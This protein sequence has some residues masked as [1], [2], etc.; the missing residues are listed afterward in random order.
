MKATPDFVFHVPHLTLKESLQIFFQSH[1]SFYKRASPMSESLDFFLVTHLIIRKSLRIF[2]SLTRP[3]PHPIFSK[4]HVL[5]SLFGIFPMVYMFKKK[6]SDTEKCHYRDVGPRKNLETLSSGEEESEVG[7]N[8]EVGWGVELLKDP[9]TLLKAEV[10]DLER[11][12]G[13][14]IRWGGL[15]KNWDKYRGALIG[16]RC[17]IYTYTI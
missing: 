6:K 8:L 10:W 15:G 14:F 16:V 13:S 5:V 9:E 1:S 3:R 12:G 17:R 4:S 2:S 7:K 11:S